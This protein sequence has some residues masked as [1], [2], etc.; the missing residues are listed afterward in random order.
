[1]HV[2]QDA[3][4]A[5]AFRGAGRVAGGVERGAARTSDGRIP[6]D[7]VRVVPRE[8]ERRVDVDVDG[9]RFTA[10]VW[11]ER[12]AKPVLHP[13]VAAGGAIVTRGFPLDPRPGERVD[14]PHQVGLWFAYGDVDGVDYWNTSEALP[15]DERAKMG[16]I[17]H[18]AIVAARSG[19]RGELDI[20]ADWM[21]PGDRRVLEERTRFVFAGGP[22]RR[23]IDRLTTLTA[24]APRVVFGDSK[25][26]LL[27]L[28]VARALELPAD[29]PEIFLD[30]AGRPTPVPVLDN[31]G[32][33]GMYVSSEGKRGHDVWGTRG[34]WVALSGRVGEQPVTIAILDHPSNPGHPT[35]WHAR[36]YGLFAANPLGRRSFDPSAP[37]ARL[38]LESGGRLRFVHRILVLSSAAAT[39]EIETAWRAFAREY[40]AAGPTAG[41]RPRPR[42]REQRDAADGARDCVGLQLGGTIDCG[43]RGR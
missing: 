38:V 23:S 39:E 31:T 32:V 8:A 19:E 37:P 27:G 20:E 12:L 42:A 22:G 26:G 11:P 18:R 28:R 10:Y 15:A 24:V 34:R 35:I 36:G 21:A 3:R 29:K 1:V 16:V 41:A 7:A 9:A 33:T 4:A 2:A 13:I 17:R 6:D 30:A 5:A 14:H 25:E 43:G 40:P